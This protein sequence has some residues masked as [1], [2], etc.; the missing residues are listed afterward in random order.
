[1]VLFRS[2]N[3]KELNQIWTFTLQ[4]YVKKIMG[5]IHIHNKLEVSVSPLN[6]VVTHDS[7]NNFVTDLYS[8]ICNVFVSFNNKSNIAINPNDANNF[9]KFY[10]IWHYGRDSMDGC[11]IIKTYYRTK[12]PKMLQLLVSR[13][14]FKHN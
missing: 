4:N 7:L 13:C 1:M 6:G 14:N 3:V 10:L 9:L 2:T 11:Y 8:N 12:V 5:K